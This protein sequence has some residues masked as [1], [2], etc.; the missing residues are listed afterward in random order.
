MRNAR[1][2][3][4]GIPVYLR[5]E[6]T[7]NI[8]AAMCRVVQFGCERDSSF[9][10]SSKR[11]DEDGNLDFIVSMVRSVFFKFNLNIQFFMSSGIMGAGPVL[12]HNLFK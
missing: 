12:F 11:D 2:L 1:S 10:L 5:F 6:N 8:P 4:Q 9:P 3:A 7:E